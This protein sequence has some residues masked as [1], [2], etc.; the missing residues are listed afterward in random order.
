M[1]L[2]IGTPR[3]ITL[4]LAEDIDLIDQ[5]GLVIYQRRLA[6][7]DIYLDHYEH[8]LSIIHAQ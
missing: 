1:S 6:A 4:R 8:R 5:I 2:F 7:A 3:Q